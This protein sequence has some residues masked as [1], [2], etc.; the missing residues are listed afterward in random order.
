LILI[1]YM[2]SPLQGISDQFFKIKL[3]NGH[4]IKAELAVDKAKGLQDRNQLCQQ[5]GM[6]FV[7]E[8][9]GIHSFWMKDTLIN[10]AMIWID[11]ERHI[12]HIESKA[13]PCKYKINP[14]DE[15]KIYS[16][17]KPSKYVL[18]INP[19]DAENLEVGMLIDMSIQ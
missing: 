1:C 12:T 16:S 10:L 11:S 2:F 5:C 7:F 6:I 19:A 15:C 13:E 4:T 3:P 18:E 17:D 9:E 14:Y 8:E